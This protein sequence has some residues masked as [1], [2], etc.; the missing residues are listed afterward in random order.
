MKFFETPSMEIVKFAVED[1]VTTSPGGGNGSQ[2]P[3][4]E[5]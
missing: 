1:I 2:L 3:E 5:Y 4:E